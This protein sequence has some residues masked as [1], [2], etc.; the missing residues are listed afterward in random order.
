MMRLPLRWKLLFLLLAPLAVFAPATVFVIHRGVSQE[1]HKE[2]NAR[3]G[4]I[5]EEAALLVVDDLLIGERQAAER[6]LADVM[7]GHKDLA[8]LFL[9]DTRGEVVA[10]TFPEGFPED[11]LAVRGRNRADGSAVRVLL[12]DRMVNDLAAP[13]LGGH[14]GVVHVGVST[15]AARGVSHEVLLRLT[16]IGVGV[17]AL[18]VLL[19]WLMTSRA[20]RRIDR[21]AE[22]VA[23]IGSGKLETRI[24][25]REPDELGKLASEFDRMAE[26]LEKGRA[27]REATLARLAQSEKLVAVG[28]LAAGVAHEIRNPLSGVVHCLD[29]LTL[30]DADTKRRGRY[31]Q[32]MHEGVTRALRIVNGLLNYA[33]RHELQMQS[34]QIDPV[35]ERVASLLESSFR[36]A[37]VRFEHVRDSALPPIEA[38]PH[39]IEQVLMNLLLNA[40]EATPREGSV[41]VTTSRSGDFARIRVIDTGCGIT[42]DAIGNIFDPFFTTKDVGAGSGLGLSVSLGMIERHGGSIEVSS[43]PGAGSSFEVLLPLRRV[44]ETGSAT[45]EAA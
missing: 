18:G 39:M 27:E 5:A 35:I 10:H 9:L 41:T 33:R 3:G 30:D 38:D 23:A 40:I 16:F 24:G 34:V 7:D 29:N 17:V 14:A 45:T 25:D 22:A 44:H 1:L 2:I 8:Y 11:L 37:G 19:T 6:K 20:T 31:Y 36:R 26:H 43:A 28:R 13:V 21:M 15:D 32:L 42:A 12:D 4:V